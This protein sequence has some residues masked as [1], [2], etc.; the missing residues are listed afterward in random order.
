MKFGR[1]Y[2]LGVVTTRRSRTMHNETGGQWPYSP[3]VTVAILTFNHNSELNDP[4]RI[5]I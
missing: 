5:P 1:R 4:N 2:Y 3:V